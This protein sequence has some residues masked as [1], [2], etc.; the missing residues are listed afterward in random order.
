MTTSSR[1]C[2]GRVP[3][4]EEE[5]GEATRGGPVSGPAPRVLPSP[6]EELGLAAALAALTALCA[7]LAFLAALLSL[8]ALLHVVLLF[9]TGLLAALLASALLAALV[10]SLVSHCSS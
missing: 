2:C 8:L 4:S 1:R 5:K 9:L 3:G 6:P 10:L 7:T